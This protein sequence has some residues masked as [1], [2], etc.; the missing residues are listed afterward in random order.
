[1]N[2]YDRLIQATL[3]AS[4]LVVGVLTTFLTERGFVEILKIGY[5]QHILWSL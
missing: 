2:A 1:L 5:L 3:F 4:L